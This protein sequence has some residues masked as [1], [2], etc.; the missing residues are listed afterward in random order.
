M[1]SIAQFRSIIIAQSS[2]IKL[3]LLCVHIGQLYLRTI[4]IYMYVYALQWK[5]SSYP[6][7][8]AAEQTLYIT[9]KRSW[10]ML[11]YWNFK[12]VEILWI[13]HFIINT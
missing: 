11:L 8:V 7:Q 3:V 9:L 12:M 6:F 13:Y 10:I 2:L 1:G 4:Y 5:G